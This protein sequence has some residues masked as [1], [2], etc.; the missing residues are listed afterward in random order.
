MALWGSSGG[1]PSMGAIVVFT[2][3]VIVMRSAGCVVNDWADR[4]F[5]GHVTRTR[6]RVLVSGKVSE[7][8]AKCLFGGLIL[9]AFIL[10]CFLNTFTIFLSLGALLLATGYP[11]MKR[12]THFPQVVLGAAFAWGIPMAYASQLNRVDSSAWWLFSAAVF[13]AM[14]YD[15]IYAMVDRE[16]DL[17][18]GV[19]STAIIFGKWD[20]VLV[21]I[22]QTLTLVCFAYWGKLIGLGI[23]YSIGMVIAICLS[24]YQQIIIHQRDPSQCFKAFVNSHWV[25]AV[26]FFCMMLDYRIFPSPF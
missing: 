8:E 25:G 11:F 16:D 13:W 20:R 21:A 5:D 7:K 24:L 4:G 23:F 1:S 12:Y 18:I 22:F 14:A 9:L 10:V 19:K 6:N 26:L 2:L 17:K 15:T 3:G